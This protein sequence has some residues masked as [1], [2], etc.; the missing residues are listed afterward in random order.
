[1]NTFLLFHLILK[2]LVI[3]MNHS[4]EKNWELGHVHY[5]NKEEAVEIFLPLSLNV[6]SG[7]TFC[8]VNFFC[9]IP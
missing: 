4:V 9:L 2:I 3:E 8:A 7:F 5:Q 1:M 6:S